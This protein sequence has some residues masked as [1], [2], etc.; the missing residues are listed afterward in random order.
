[1]F[2]MMARSVRVSKVP[3]KTPASRRVLMEEMCAILCRHDQ[4]AQAILKK[5]DILN[6]KYRKGKQKLR[7]FRFHSA[8]LTHEIERNRQKLADHMH[9]IRHQEQTE[10]DDRLAR[11]EEMVGSQIEGHKRLISEQSC[12]SASFPSARRTR[13]AARELT[14]P[15]RDDHAARRSRFP[16]DSHEYRKRHSSRT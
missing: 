12:A 2:A 9:A 5:Y 14:V 13:F 3:A 11:L 7:E 8:E 10:I 1:M 15:V 6:A 16:G 4:D